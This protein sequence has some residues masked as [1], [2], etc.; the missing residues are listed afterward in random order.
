MEEVNY[1]EEMIAAKDDDNKSLWKMKLDEI[2]D[3]ST[4]T[5]GFDYLQDQMK[6]HANKFFDKGTKVA[7]RRARNYA[8]KIKDVVSRIRVVISEA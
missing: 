7:G 2:N 3:Y 1:W 6:D 4:L 5:E 8:Q